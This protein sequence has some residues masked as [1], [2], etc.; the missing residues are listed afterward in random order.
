[1]II[2]IDNYDS[3]TYNLVQYLR[4]LSARVDVY[5]NDVISVNDVAALKPSAIIL[6]PGPGRP[7]TAGISLDIVKQLSGEAVHKIYLLACLFLADFLEP[8]I[9]NRCQ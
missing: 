2:M 9:R 6:S 4:Q 8:A 1:M 3:F 5:R 7:E